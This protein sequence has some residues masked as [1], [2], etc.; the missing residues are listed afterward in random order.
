MEEVSEESRTEWYVVRQA[1]EIELPDTPYNLWCSGELWDHVNAEEGAKVEVIG[2]EVCI[3]GAPRPPLPDS[4]RARHRTVQ[5]VW[6]ENER[7]REEIRRGW[8][9]SKREASRDQ[10]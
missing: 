4:P 8:E 1:Y 6:E 10:T 9:A 5:E 7:L 3:D 2:G